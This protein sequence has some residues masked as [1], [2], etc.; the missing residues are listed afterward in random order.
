MS[1]RRK[2]SLGQNFLVNIK[3]AERM[4]RLFKPGKEDVILEIGP[5]R[6]VLTG[7]LAP[8]AKRITA[9]E[10]D[11]DLCDF[12]REEFSSEENV[13]I[14]HENILDLDLSGIAGESGT[15]RIISNLPYS[16][17]K[18]VVVKIIDSKE[19][20][21]DA[22]LMV[23]REVAERMMSP[24]GVKSYG[25]LSVLV[26][27]HFE[28]EKWMDLSPGSFRPVPKVRSSLLHLIPREMNTG[29]G[30]SEN[31]FRRVLRACFS[32]RRKKIISSLSGLVETD[33]ER[34]SA[35]LE[36]RGISSSRRPE[37]FTPG[38]YAKICVVISALE[39]GGRS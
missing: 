25:S 6:G 2:K 32:R 10:I 38:E 8:L 19:R 3:A 23:Q 26:Q 9:V 34:L 18:A 36:A 7:R 29:P 11:R 28:V 24:P 39:G 27:S 4:V 33:S 37:E 35:A 14:R 12:L 16:I 30:W 31:L 15:L 5:G 20:V 1:G 17:A 21:A 13:V 22:A